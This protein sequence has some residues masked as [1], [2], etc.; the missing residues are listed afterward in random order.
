MFNFERSEIGKG[1]IIVK[2]ICLV[3]SFERREMLVD[4]YERRDM[5][6]DN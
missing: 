5:L 4:S 6:V 3:D 2:Q 1:M